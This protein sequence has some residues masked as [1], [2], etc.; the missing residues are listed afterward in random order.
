MVGLLPASPARGQ[1]PVEEI[2]LI[3]MGCARLRI[4]VFPLVED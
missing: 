1:G 3:P 2:E 4:T